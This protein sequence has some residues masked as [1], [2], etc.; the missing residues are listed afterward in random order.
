MLPPN[1][2]ICHALASLISYTAFQRINMFLDFTKI[3]I[4]KCSYPAVMQQYCWT[5]LLPIKQWTGTFANFCCHQLTSHMLLLLRGAST[6]RSISLC[7]YLFGSTSN[8][9]KIFFS[10][11]IFLPA[12][13]KRP[14]KKGTLCQNA[15][16]SHCFIVIKWWEATQCCKKT[17]H[18]ATL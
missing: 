1:P 9:T 4:P 13:K 16:F 14:W 3:S 10:S 17:V 18:W 5:F 15:D 7:C 2:C 12:F 6:K 11:L 8:K